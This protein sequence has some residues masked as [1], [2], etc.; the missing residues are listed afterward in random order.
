MMRVPWL[1]RDRKSR[2]AHLFVGGAATLL[3]YQLT[4]RVHLFEP[5]LLPF[6]RVDKAMPF[7]PWTIWIYFTEYA[8][9]VYAYFFMRDL[10]LVTRYYYA[11]MTIL[12]VSETVFV[13]FPVTYPRSLFPAV[14][15]SINIHAMNFM[16]NYMDA[17]ANCLPS[18]HV[19]SCYISSLCFWQENKWKSAFLVMWSSF[20][21]FATMTTKQHYFTDV[22]T[23]MILTAVC[24]WFF[25][26][27]LELD[28]TGS[29]DGAIA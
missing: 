26:Y 10:K 7:L 25:F 28:G 23:A 19:S 22:W 5:Q 3:L 15:D 11:Y 14:G 2:W 16:R 24:Y 27:K 17:P 4:N 8:F 20:V 6:G 13:L 21:A 29:S 1:V 9:F 12:L 18:L